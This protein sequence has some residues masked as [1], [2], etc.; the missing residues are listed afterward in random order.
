MKHILVIDDEP[1]ILH[2]VRDYLAIAGYKVDVAV[3]FNSAMELIRHCMPDLVITDIVLPD[4]NGFDIVSD[5][6]REFVEIKLIVMTGAGLFDTATLRSSSR[7]LG[8]E[9][10]LIKPFT[11]D[12][13]IDMVNR[14]LTMADDDISF[15]C[16]VNGQDHE[17]KKGVRHCGATIAI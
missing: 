3:D 6:S 12:D 16:N 5:I 1:Q 13:L 8:A 7:E 10:L 11:G 4:K 14:I 9:G 17:E 15:L 2:V